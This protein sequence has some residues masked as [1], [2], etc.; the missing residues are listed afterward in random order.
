MA[1]RTGPPLRL[2]A[3]VGACS[4]V[5]Y[6]LVRFL[7]DGV[8]AVGSTPFTPSAGLAIP[9]GVFFGVPA[10]VGIAAGAL[11]VGVARAGIPLWVLFEALSLFLLSLV[12]WRAWALYF[13]PAIELSSSTLGQ[14]TVTGPAGWIR[15]GS[16]TVLASVGAAAF[17]AWGGELLGLFPFYVTLPDVAARYVL[18]TTVAGVP[19]AV[20]LS[21]VAGQ[22]GSEETKQPESAPSRTRR[23]AFVLIPVVWGLAGFAGGVGFSIRERL[24]VTTFE[25]FGVEFLYHWVHPDI[26]GQGARRVQVALGAVLLVAWLFTLRQPD[27]SADS[28]ERYISPNSQDQHVQDQHVQNHHTQDQHVQNH[29][30]QD[31]HPQDHNAPSTRREQSPSAQSDRGELR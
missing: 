22:T 18:A 27:V 19:L 6:L 10:A 3:L 4:F 15:F 29:H 20:V 8:V 25:E 28:G 17:L 1:E 21:I 13:D 23:R 7:L 24:D 11:V 2:W 30:T 9:L 14:T 5:G 12:S 26:F 31:Q 16:L